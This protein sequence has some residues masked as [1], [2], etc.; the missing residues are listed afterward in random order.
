MM[1]GRYVTSNGKVFT[2][3]AKKIKEQ[4]NTFKE[5]N[6]KME[7]ERIEFAKVCGSYGLNPDFYG[8]GCI[9]ENG[10]FF[11]LIGLYDGYGKVRSLADTC[12]TFPF[13]KILVMMNRQVKEDL[14]ELLEKADMLGIERDTPKNK[15]LIR[16]MREEI[17]NRMKAITNA[18]TIYNG[19]MLNVLAS[20]NLPE[21]A[22]CIG[23]QIR[24]DVFEFVSYRSEP[25][26]DGSPCRRPF[27]LENICMDNT[28]PARFRRVGYKGLV[29]AMTKY[30]ENNHDK[31]MLSMIAEMTPPFNAMELDVNAAR[32]ESA[33]TASYTQSS[34][35][36]FIAAAV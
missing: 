34:L 20:M 23:C 4:K 29:D 26:S 24:G 35:F 13:D 30:A 36:D 1:T 32:Q 28:V 2:D 16:E 19:N 27:I 31:D 11:F 5:Q 15:A 14:S 21:E 10:G 22:Y 8:H 9:D 25:M 7:K 33:H 18:K 17:K 3:E 6:K 12:T